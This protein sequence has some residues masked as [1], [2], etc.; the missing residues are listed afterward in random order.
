MTPAAQPAD[1]FNITDHVLKL[2]SCKF[3]CGKALLMV[4]VRKIG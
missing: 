3:A 1:Q 2:E 4:T